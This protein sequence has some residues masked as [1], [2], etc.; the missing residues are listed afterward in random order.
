MLEEMLPEYTYQY[1]VFL[2][3]SYLV[4][5]IQEAEKIG[6]GEVFDEFR[7]IALVREMQ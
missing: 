2:Y 7:V 4:D 5:A 3:Y 1:C 6:Y